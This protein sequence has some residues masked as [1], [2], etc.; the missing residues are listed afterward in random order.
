MILMETQPRPPVK[1]EQETSQAANEE[2]KK[3][4]PEEGSGKEDNAGTEKDQ[5]DGETVKAEDNTNTMKDGNEEEP[6]QTEAQDKEKSQNIV[7][8]DPI[9]DPRFQEFL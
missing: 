5:G 2:S 1:E 8:E 7:E 4:V 9:P 6:D 3:A